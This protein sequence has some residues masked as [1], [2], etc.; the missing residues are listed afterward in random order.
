MVSPLIL[1]IV[2]PELPGST[3]H[4]DAVKGFPESLQTYENRENVFGEYSVTVTFTLKLLLSCCVVETPMTHGFSREMVLSQ[5][6]MVMWPR[7]VLK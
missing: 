6:S 5:Q 1:H 4:S 3:L 2:T 7:V